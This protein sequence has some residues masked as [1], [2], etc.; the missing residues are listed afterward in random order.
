MSD[1]KVTVLPAEDEPVKKLPPVVYSVTEAAIAA[2][3]EK[4]AALTADTPAGYEEVVLALR[5]VRRTRTGIEK[6]RKALK[7]DALDYG[8]QVDSEAQRWT[9]LL[10]SIEKPLEEKKQAVDDAKAAEKARLERERIEKIEADIR[11]NR[12]AEEKQLREKREAEE[13]RIAKERADLDAEREQLRVA[14]E[15]H[16]V[17]SERLQAIADAAAKAAQEEADRVAAARR[18]QE[19]E[20]QAERR[21]ED[22]RLAA[23]REAQELERRRVRAAE[24][25]ERKRQM[26][27]YE[28]QL[29][30]EKAE[31]DRQRAHLE[32]KQKAEEAKR[33]QEVERLKAAAIETVYDYAKTMCPLVPAA[34]VSAVCAAMGD[35]ISVDEAK[36]GLLRQQEELVAEAEAR[37][38]AA[39]KRVEELKPDLEKLHEYAEA[40]RNV[41]GP[42]V[43]SDEAKELV[44]TVQSTLIELS[45]SIV[46]SVKEIQ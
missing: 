8:R 14:Q 13:A 27:A 24:D 22:E 15:A 2:T 34:E 38:A 46:E 40:I 21:R 43:T 35:F 37:A 17:E 9:G 20:A 1:V 7:A 42:E 18:R 23:E 32:A 6:Q 12:E 26:D 11:A 4:Y 16:R 44:I 30:K 33:R 29:R 19:E 3:R 36:A 41:R 45:K 31:L 5:E 10:E 28:E 25:A 39:A